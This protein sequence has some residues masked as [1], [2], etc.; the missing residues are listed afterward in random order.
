MVAQRTLILLPTSTITNP[1]VT[2][3]GEATYHEA[4][5]P[6]DPISHTDGSHMTGGSPAVSKTVGLGID[7]TFVEKMAT[8]LAVRIFA[9]HH[10]FPTHLPTPSP[11]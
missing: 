6:G 5:D 3:V 10:L 2:L 8:I 1:G 4:L 11:T 7:D 9:L